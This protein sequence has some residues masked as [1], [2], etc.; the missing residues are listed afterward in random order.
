MT[1]ETCSHSYRHCPI[2]KWHVGEHWMLTEACEI[3]QISHCYHLGASVSHLCAF[4]TVI[5][6]HEGRGTTSDAPESDCA[7]A[8]PNGHDGLGVQT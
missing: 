4:Q 7:G 8:F 5:F 1:A 6:L 2:W 3:E